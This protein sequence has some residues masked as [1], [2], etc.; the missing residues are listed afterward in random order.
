MSAVEPKPRSTASESAEPGN[1]Q[2]VHPPIGN[3]DSSL[4]IGYPDVKARIRRRLHSLFRRALNWGSYPWRRKRFIQQLFTRADH[5]R[6]CPLEHVAYTDPGLHAEEL[7]VQAIAFYLPQFYPIPENDRWWGKGFTEWTNVTR[8]LPQFL[9]HYQPRL[10]GDLG[11]YDLRI[12]GVMRQQAEWAKA[13]G[14]L[15]FCFHHYWFH[16]RR[17]LEMPLNRF[18][19]DRTIAIRFCLCWANE[20]WSRRWDGSEHEILMPQSHSPADDLAFIDSL[21]P[22]FTD[23]RY[24]RVDGKPL[25]VVYRA[26]LLPEPAATAERWR[27][28]VQEHGLPDL[29]L[30]AAKSFD[31][32][33]PTALGF[34]A[35]LEFPPHQLRMKDTTLDYPLVN[36]GF[37]GKIFDYQT[38]AEYAGKREYPDYTCFKTVMPS[39]DNSARKRSSA[40]IFSGST[41]E[42]YARWLQDAIHT[43]LKHRP[44]ERL[45]F[46]NAWN[47]WS[48]GAYLEPDQRFGY[49]YLHATAMALAQAAASGDPRNR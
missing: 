34:D 36:P 38:C 47:E 49:A 32:G 12:D 40:H 27:N 31:V 11:F 17:L 8:A 16:G 3:E 4:R 28:R 46:I 7:P 23:P 22:A 15:G 25:L 10:P 1:A 41:P 19:Q 18:L 24:L 37:Q 29:Y 14:I 21:I 45:L 26:T 20:N 2:R 30:V 44:S 35:G 13:H 5:H 42:R 43:T 48:E 39:W 9:G 33:N 6:T